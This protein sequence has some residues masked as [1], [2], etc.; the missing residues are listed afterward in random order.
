MLASASKFA[1]VI[2]KD[3]GNKDKRKLLPIKCQ[4]IRYDNDVIVLK[5]TD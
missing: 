5:R 3:H 4:L 2:A 1:H